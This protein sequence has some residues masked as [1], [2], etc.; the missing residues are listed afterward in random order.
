MYS[1]VAV[2]LYLLLLNWRK[3]KM[4]KCKNKSI[5]ISKET[6]ANLING[7]IESDFFKFRS[8]I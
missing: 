2:T 6:T 4:Q 1:N 8:E 3:R 5:N 7:A